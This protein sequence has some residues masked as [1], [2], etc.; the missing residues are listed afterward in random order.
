MGSF[1]KAFGGSFGCMAGAM[2]VPLG[3]LALLCGGCLFALQGPVQEAREA[4]RE[5]ERKTTSAAAEKTALNPNSTPESANAERN[6][7]QDVDDAK[8]ESEHLPLLNVTGMAGKAPDEVEAILGIA[9]GTIPA[10]SDLYPEDSPG[11]YREYRFDWLGVTVE[12]YRGRAVG[13]VVDM[14]DH[15]TRTVSE[16]L[17]LIGLSEQELQQTFDTPAV[18]KTR[19]GFRKWVGAA[20]GVVFKTLIATQEKSGA[21]VQVSVEFDR[22][23][24]PRA[25]RTAGAELPD[26]PSEPEFE[27]HFHVFFKNGT[28]KPVHAYVEEGSAYV[29]TGTTGGKGKYPKSMIDR[30]EPVISPDTM[31]QGMRTWRDALGAHEALAEFVS[32]ENGVVR[33]RKLNGKT[34]EMRLERLSEDDQEFM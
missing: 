4:A 25:S 33:L 30:I 23:K 32:L 18:A 17:R 6:T 31:P 22:S 1:G 14:Q 11:E 28:N 21:W 16:A 34:V 13:V 24:L 15:P 29:F 10:N 2:L 20:N 7:T 26:K 12:F 5:Q 19:F 27:A 8:H 9:K 3:V